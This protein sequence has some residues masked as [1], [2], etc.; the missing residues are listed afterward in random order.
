MASMFS[1]AGR[2]IDVFSIGPPVTRPTRGRAAR[3]RE[4]DPATDRCAQDLAIQLRP[5]EERRARARRAEDEVQQ[6]HA[7]PRGLCD[8]LLLAPG[9]ALASAATLAESNS[10]LSPTI[11]TASLPMRPP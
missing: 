8:R 10:S 9:T 5:E 11:R 1:A 2:G 4:E 6:L 7:A 3:D